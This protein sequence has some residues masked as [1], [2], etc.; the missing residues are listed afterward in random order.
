MLN[1]RYFSLIYLN[2]Y[3]LRH[4]SRQTFQPVKCR[5]K[6]HVVNLSGAMVPLKNETAYHPL[7]YPRQTRNV[8]YPCLTE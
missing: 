2:F 8:S 5:Q 4:R 7:F 3:T 1:S 6:P